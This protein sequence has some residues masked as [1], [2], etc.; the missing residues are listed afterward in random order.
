[1]FLCV[2]YSY[3]RGRHKLRI[4]LVL[5]GLVFVALQ[6]DVL[7]NYFRMYGRQFGPLQ[8][9]EFSHM[10]V[11]VLVTPVFVWLTKESLEKWGHRLPINLTT[12]F[13][14]TMV[15]S[16]SAFY[17]V[18]ELWDEIY[19]GGHRI[20]G[21]YDTAS[22]LQFDLCGILIGSV[23]ANFLLKSPTKHRASENQTAI[24]TTAC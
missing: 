9:D 12:L 18:I 1:M 11:Q 4:P 13:A 21:Q 15:F 2:V 22:D 19:F 17:E 5:L 24:R 20:W 16:L 14:A 3:L 8:Y 7:G 10:T 23:L 6:V